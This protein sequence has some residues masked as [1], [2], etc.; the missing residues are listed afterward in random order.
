LLTALLFQTEE[1]REELKISPDNETVVP[2]P[3]QERSLMSTMNSSVSVGLAPTERK[4]KLASDD[5]ISP[6]NQ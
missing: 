6:L 5:Q 1:V 4:E 2:G 3:D